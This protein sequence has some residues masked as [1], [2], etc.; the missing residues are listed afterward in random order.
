MEVRPIHKIAQPSVV[1]WAP[2]SG[3]GCID[4]ELE[5]ELQSFSD[6]LPA[7]VLAASAL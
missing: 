6:V 7:P 4:D 1:E 3:S 5:T 2:L